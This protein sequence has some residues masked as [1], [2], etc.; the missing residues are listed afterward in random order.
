MG[1]SRRHNKSSVGRYPHSSCTR[2]VLSIRP[3]V[4][5]PS[6][7]SMLAAS[8]VF[9]TYWY[10]RAQC[11]VLVCFLPSRRTFYTPSLVTDRISGKRAIITVR[12]SQSCHR[13]STSPA[14]VSDR[15]QLHG[16][17]GLYQSA[18]AS[19]SNTVKKS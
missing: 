10:C 15:S 17:L 12:T 13:H 5:G 6:P 2:K 9:L 7:F 3:N 14:I 18:F 4:A 11:F 19:Y 1:T 16:L 8:Y